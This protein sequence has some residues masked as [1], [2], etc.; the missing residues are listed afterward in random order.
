MTGSPGRRAK[1][2]LQELADT[3]L[4]GASPEDLALRCREAMGKIDVFTWSQWDWR[5][6]GDIVG[7]VT[8]SREELSDKQLMNLRRI[9]FI[10]EHE[11][12]V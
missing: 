4:Q 3:A 1:R 10:A 9:V 12:S 2:E 7:R 5:F 11:A 8:Y 6:A